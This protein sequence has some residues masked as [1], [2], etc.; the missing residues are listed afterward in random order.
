MQKNSDLTGSKS[1]TLL[2]TYWIRNP[3]YEVT[4]LGQTSLTPCVLLELFRRQSE[5][6]WEDKQ[7]W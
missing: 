7:I 1:K 4:L 6:E 2:E 3:G 5:D